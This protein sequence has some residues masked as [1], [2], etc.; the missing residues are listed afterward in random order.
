MPPRPARSAEENALTLLVGD[1]IVPVLGR[2]RVV[3]QATVQVAV[4]LEDRDL[5][6][7]VMARLP[8][9]RDAFFTRLYR[10]GADGRL[11]AAGL[12]LDQLK[13]LFQ[14]AADRIVG[15]DTVEVLILQAHYSR[16]SKKPRSRKQGKPGPAP[17][18]PAG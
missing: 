18:S 16:L 2:D 8:R 11:G 17:P 9:L 7:A 14:K 13:R 6:K 4:W 3:A 12:D 15:R 10:L 5:L 1:L